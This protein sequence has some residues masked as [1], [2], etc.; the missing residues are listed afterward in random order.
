MPMRVLKGEWD[1][2]K[3]DSLWNWLPRFVLLATLGLSACIQPR[4]P[5]SPAPTPLLPTLQGRRR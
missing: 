5:S 3:L 2:N 4:I 1:M